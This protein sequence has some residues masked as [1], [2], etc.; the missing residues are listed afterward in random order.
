ME[1]IEVAESMVFWSWK[2]VIAICTFLIVFGRT[3]DG[4][5]RQKRKEIILKALAE[6]EHKLAKIPFGAYQKWLAVKFIF[7]FEKLITPHN[8]Q[9]IQEY[10]PEPFIKPISWATGI[11]DL[12]FSIYFTYFKIVTSTTAIILIIL[13]LFG[14][15][16]SWVFY[17]LMV[18]A[19]AYLILVTIPTLY[20]SNFLYQLCNKAYEK[21]LELAKEPPGGET[22]NTIG[23]WFVV[24][25]LFKIEKPEAF[26]NF[27]KIFKLPSRVIIIATASANHPLNMFLSVICRAILVSVLATLGS[28]SVAINISDPSMSY[29]WMEQTNDI[30]TPLNPVVLTLLNGVFNL[31]TIFVSVQLL[32]W[33]ISRQRSIVAAACI[34]IFVSSGLSLILLVILIAIGQFSGAGY[35]TSFYEAYKYVLVLP[36]VGISLTES[37][38]PLLPIIF[39]TILPVVLYLLLPVLLG[40]VL[41][42]LA[43]IASYCSGLAGEQKNTPF[44]GLSVSLAALLTL[45]KAFSEWPWFMHQLEVSMS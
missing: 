15:L 18:W 45:A 11:P 42:P 29:F 9:A 7:F 1:N 38:W 30:M 13:L 8:V 27:Q 16:E 31:V 22:T 23:S 10:R 14:V 36:T 34:D 35:F 4:L 12:G 43:I 25:R 26:C 3:V 39:T 41:K 2:G 5:I 28:I 32:S 17:C 44:F 19:W 20:A 6:Y 21:V 40:L 24:M 33:F 37:S